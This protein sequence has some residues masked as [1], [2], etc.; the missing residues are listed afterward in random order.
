MQINPSEFEAARRVIESLGYEVGLSEI[1]ERP[2]VTNLAAHLAGND[3]EAFAEL[4]EE[5]TVI[6]RNLRNLGI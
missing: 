6:I 5:L 3:R 2:D 1:A 4:E